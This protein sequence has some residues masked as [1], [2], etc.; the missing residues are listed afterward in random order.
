MVLAVCLQHHFNN[1]PRVEVETDPR[2]HHYYEFGANLLGMHHGHTTKSNDLPLVM[3][4]DRAEAWGRTKFRRW[5]CG[6][7]HHDTVKEYQGC[8][9]ETF[10]TLAPADAWHASKGYR[11][12]NDMKLDVWHKD[13]GH[14][15]RHIVGIEA[16]LDE[17]GE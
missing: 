17:V 10:R 8:T 16:V 7:I 9:V 15:N 5:Y 3:A 6:H 14:I 13:Y 1:N 12:G 11:S 2:Q 4:A